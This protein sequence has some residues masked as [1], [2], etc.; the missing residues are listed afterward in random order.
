MTTARQV[1]GLA[2][3]RAGEWSGQSVSGQIFKD[4][5]HRHAAHAGGAGNRAL[6]EPFQVQFFDRRLFVG[7]LLSLGIKRAIRVT[8]FTVKLLL[9]ALCMTI[10]AQVDRATAATGD[11]NHARFLFAF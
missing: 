6:G 5:G 11:D 3:Q 9:A 1:Q 8:V 2:V 7:T 10:L 4:G